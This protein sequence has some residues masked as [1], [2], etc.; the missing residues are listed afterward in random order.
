MATKPSDNPLDPPVAS[1]LPADP[2]KVPPKVPPKAPEIGDNG[3]YAGTGKT[4]EELVKEFGTNPDGSP[5]T[6]PKPDI[7]VRHEI[8][9]SRL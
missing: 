4:A 3:G 9:P 8:H 2:P 7:P 1:T 5:A 6:E